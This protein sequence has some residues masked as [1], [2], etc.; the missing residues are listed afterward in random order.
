MPE[1][2]LGPEVENIFVPVLEL[3][4]EHVFASIVGYK[5]EHVH[6]GELLAEREAVP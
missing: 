2:G 1:P 6:F 4:L 5:L 3:E